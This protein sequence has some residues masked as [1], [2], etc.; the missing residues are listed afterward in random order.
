VGDLI[1]DILDEEE[2]FEE[3]LRNG[4]RFHLDKSKNHS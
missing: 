3:E 1:W 2:A 4:S